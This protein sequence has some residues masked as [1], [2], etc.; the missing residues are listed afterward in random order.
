MQIRL[1]IK[2]FQETMKA[3]LRT[4]VNLSDPDIA[5]EIRLT[6][7]AD[8][9]T[10]FDGA[11]PV[12]LGGVVY[13]GVYWAPLSPS[14]L[15]QKPRRRGGQIL[16][17]TGELQQSFTSNA[18]IF[19]AANNEVVVGTALPK[20]ADLQRGYIFGRLR[21]GRERPILF[22]HDQL[23]QDVLQIINEAIARRQ[24]P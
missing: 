2:Q 21:P 4:P 17:D 6:V 14:Y 10:R 3:L 8:V 12:E 20:A 13:G 11:P 23:V 7:L 15:R 24:G 22:I 18:A 19:Q 1:E 9:D 16:R 5:L